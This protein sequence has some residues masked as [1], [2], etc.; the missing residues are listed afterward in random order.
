M[1]SKIKSTNTNMKFTL[2]EKFDRFNLAKLLAIENPEIIDD[3]YKC[4]IHKYKNYSN[5]GMVQV[6]Y[7]NTGIGRLKCRVKKLKKEDTCTTQ[8]TMYNLAKSALCK[9][10]YHDIDIVNCHFVLA[11]QVFKKYNLKCKKLSHF[12]KN[13]EDVFQYMYDTYDLNRKQCKKIYVKLLYMESNKPK[14][15]FEYPEV[16]DFYREIDTNKQIVCNDIKNNK[17]RTKAITEKGEDYYN[18]NGTAFAYQLQ[19][20]ECTILLY[21]KEWFEKR[22]Y[23]IGALIHDGLHIEKL[24]DKPITEDL[25]SDLSDDIY[26]DCNGWDVELVEKEFATIEELE[27]IVV[28]DNDMEAGQLFSDYIKNDYIE[29]EGRTFIKDRDIWCE[30]NER[31]TKKK[32]IQYMTAFEIKKKNDKDELIPYSK[33]QKGCNAILQFTYPNPDDDFVEDLWKSNIGYL[34]YKNG[35]YDFKQGKLIPYNHDI[36]TTIKINRDFV[37]AK[38]ECK[39]VIWDKVLLPIFNKDM[40]MINCWLNYMAR[41]LYGHIEDK[42][43]AVGMGERNSGKGV[44]VSCLENTFK[45]YI[46]TTNSENFCYKDRNS[47]D[48]AKANS[49]MVSTEFARIV[50]TNEITMDSE[51]K[52]KINGNC[53][54]KLSSGG[55]YIEAR[56]NFKDE[57]QFKSQSRFMIFCNDLP[58]IEPSD[59]KETA[60]MFQ[61]PSKFLDRGDER[62]D[63][64]IKNSEGKII[65]A[66]YEKDDNIKRLLS[67]VD[68]INAFQEIILEHYGDRVDIPESMKVEQE[69]FKEEETDEKKF[70]DMFRFPDDK[71]WND[72]YNSDDEEECQDSDERDYL[73]VTEINYMI[74][75]KGI[76]V[77]AQKYKKWLQK[78]G[79]EKPQQ[80]KRNTNG[81]YAVVWTNIRKRK[82]NDDDEYY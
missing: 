1:T 55:D 34:C 27:E 26:N 50:V 82:N 28:C 17:Y 40:D 62:L 46:V 49:W 69:D 71:D 33:N 70:C 77:S 63:N 75:K 51:G 19:T 43:W 21:M 66:F 5:K 8:T 38:P 61:F 74:K 14:Q 68:Y 10:I 9:N 22:K 48:S 58:P 53:I 30:K 11:E 24:K 52:I 35:V 20:I 23:I 42:N 60:Y 32:L 72:N 54:K 65:T 56:Q 16:Y 76:A 41:G 39:Q 7:E 25:L 59:C 78:R 37:K 4:R 13:R 36:K 15:S 67:E 80:K 44:L 3:E 64:P 73:F 12:N 57:I 79:C 6:E 47:G 45:Q 2:F 29:C 18:I 81:Q 31:D